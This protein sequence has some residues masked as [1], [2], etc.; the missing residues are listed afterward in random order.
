MSKYSKI[1][2]AERP[3]TFIEDKTFRKE[4]ADLPSESSLKAN[5]VLVKVEYLSL[6]PAMR[7]WLNDTRCR[8]PA[9]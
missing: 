3:K 6:D 7:G 9:V 1:V 4:T 8:D 5:D 2:L